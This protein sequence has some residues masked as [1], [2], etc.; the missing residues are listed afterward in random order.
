MKT[1]YNKYD[2]TKINTLP[3]VS[4]P[5]RTIVVFTENEARK[6]VDYLLSFP[7]VGIDTE[8]KPSFKKGKSNKVALL[9]VSTHDTCFLFRLNRIGLTESIKRF[10]ED[11]KTLK[12]GISLGDDLRELHKRGDFENGSFLDLQNHMNELGIQD[13]S[14]QKIFANLF[15]QKISKNQRLTNWEA[16]SLTEKQQRYAATDA[17]TCILIYEEY[18]RLMESNDYELIIVP[19]PEENIQVSSTDDTTKEDK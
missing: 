17:W 19:E 2:K 10:L 3:A 8:T 5:G 12:V 14:L 16:E 4:F 7:L 11:T 13:L 15:E 18:L 6:A 9:Q 1:L